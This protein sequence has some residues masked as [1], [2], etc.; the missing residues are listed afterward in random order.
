[1]LEV[2]TSR[3][4]LRGEYMIKKRTMLILSVILIVVTASTVLLLDNVLSIRFGDKVVLPKSQLEALEDM[5]ADFTKLL[6]LKNF[7]DKY[8]Y[9]DVSEVDFADG[10]FK[11]LFESLDDPYSE[12]MNKKEYEAFTT[13]TKGSFS[14]IGIIVAPGK[15]NLITIVSPI[16]DTPGEK[17]GLRSGDMIVKVN[18][19]EYKAD[20]MDEAIANM[21]GKKGTKVNLTIAREGLAEPFDIEIKRDDVR[22][23]SVK[24]RVIENN[25]GVIKIT[26]FDELTFKDFDK[27]LNAL[28]KKNIKGLIIDLR[29]NPGGSLDQCTKIAD[30]LL[31]KQLIVYTKDRNGKTHEINS[32]ASKVDLPLAILVNGGSASASEILT[33]AVKDSKSG[34]IIGTTTF[35]KGLVQTVRKLSD[36]TG[37]KMTISQYFTPNG[38][39]IH[40]KGIEP[41]IVIDMPEELIK[42]PEVADSEDPQLQ[43]AITVIKQDM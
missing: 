3:T 16:E 19:V 11:G 20:Q 33:G 34:T 14:G 43:K 22:L 6:Y 4:K 30:R 7:I 2:F 38:T 9:Q 12:Y 21:K 26:M 35:G 28:E 37:F 17:A 41:N 15:N 32:D 40:G 8:Y 42:K 18:G 5:E 36:G 29:N 13:H 10:I 23:K 1:M 39:Y 31:G 27:A 24:A 25:I